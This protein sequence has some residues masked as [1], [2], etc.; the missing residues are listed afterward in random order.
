MSDDSQSLSQDYTNLL[1]AHANL[2]NVLGVLRS[3]TYTGSIAGNVHQANSFVQ[4]ALADMAT[5][6][7][8]HPEYVEPEVTDDAE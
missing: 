1:N 5:Q 2:N 8:E 4:Q 7:K 3:G 6:V